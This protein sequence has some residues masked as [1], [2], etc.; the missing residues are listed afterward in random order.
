MVTEVVT[1]LRADREVVRVT[2]RTRE[3]PDP[4][5]VAEVPVAIR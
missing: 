3:G 4:E 5:Q 2:L 1:L